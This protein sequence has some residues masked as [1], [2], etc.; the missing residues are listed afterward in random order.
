MTIA[1][2]TFAEKINT[3]TVLPVSNIPT[4]KAFPTVEDFTGITQSQ[5]G[6]N[7]QD[8][9]SST[10]GSGKLTPGISY[11]LGPSNSRVYP[12]QGSV[13]LASASANPMSFKFDSTVVVTGLSFILMDAGGA[14]SAYRVDYYN[15]SNQLIAEAVVPTSGVSE[16]AVSLPNVQPGNSISTVT[17]TSNYIGEYGISNLQWCTASNCALVPYVPSAM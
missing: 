12:Y 10:V 16:F 11:I 5:L 9:N 3:P 4:Q 14:H 8:V 2:L 17:I 7:N 1:N 6:Y 13:F 15:S